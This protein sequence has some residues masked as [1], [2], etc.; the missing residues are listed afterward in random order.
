MSN[1]AIVRR[2]CVL[3]LLVA[4]LLS[5]L[6]ALTATVAAAGQGAAQEPTSPST[7]LPSSGP[8]SPAGE[9]IPLERLVVKVEPSLR[10]AMLAGTKEDV[11]VLVFS[12]DVPAL[13]RVME[14]YPHEGLLGPNAERSNIP[15]AIY[16]KMP[17]RALEDV[18]RLD[19]TLFVMREQVLRPDFMAVTAEVVGAE[20][21]PAV[22]KLTYSPEEIRS[23][24][25]GVPLM[26]ERAGAAKDLPGAP[27]PSS[28]GGGPTPT[29]TFSSALHHAF[30]ANANGYTGNGVQVAEVDLGVDFGH[31][32]LQGTW[33]LFNVSRVPPAVLAAKP[34]LANYDGWPLA[35]NADGV[36]AYLAGKGAVSTSHGFVSTDTVLTP[37]PIGADQYLRWNR[38]SPFVT[39]GDIL[40]ISTVGTWGGSG[41][42]GVYFNP[43]EPVVAQPVIVPAGTVQLNIVVSFTCADIDAALVYDANNN[44]VPEL[45]ELIS[46]APTSTGANPEVFAAILNPA[47]ANRWFVMLL[48][49]DGAPGC[50]TDLLISFIS[51]VTQTTDYRVTGIPSVSNQYHVGKHWDSRLVSRYFI[52]PGVLVVDSFSANQYDRVYVDL[53]NNFD[54]TDDTA[55]MR[56]NPVGT[57]DIP[58]DLNGDGAPEAPDGF[59]DLSSGAVV[60]ITNAGQRTGVAATVG[61][62]VVTGTVAVGG[63]VWAQLPDPG[64]ITNRNPTIYLNGNPWGVASVFDEPLAVT[65]GSD[66]LQLRTRSLIVAGSVVLRGTNVEVVDEHSFTIANPASDT[67]FT[68]DNSGLLNFNLYRERMSPTWYGPKVVP[69]VSGLD[70]TVALATGTVTLLPRVRTNPNPFIQNL[71]GDVMRAYYNYTGTVSPLDYSV[72]TST[73]AITLAYP[74]KATSTMRADY[75]Y[76]AWTLDRVTGNLSLT[77]A[78]TAGDRITADYQYGVTPLPY[79][80]VITARTGADNHYWGSGDLVMFTGALYGSHGTNVATM[81]AGQGRMNRIRPDPPLQSVVLTVPSRF[82]GMAPNAKIV[83]IPTILLT[84]SI[85][86][87]WYFGV[88]GYDGVPGTGDDSQIITNSWGSDLTLSS[89]FTAIERFADWL[90]SQYAGGRAIIVKSAGNNGYGYGTFSDEGIAGIVT[91]GASS[92]WFYRSTPEFV[93]DRGPNPAYGDAAGFSA[94]GPTGAGQ[95]GVDILFNGQFVYAA[96]PLNSFFDATDA[97]TL[98]SGTSFSAPLAAGALALIY[99]AF[100]QAHAGSFPMAGLAK[101]LLMSGADP[102][103]DAF[104]SGAGLGNALRSTNL[105]AV[106]G[107]IRASPHSWYPGDYRGTDYPLSVHLLAAGESDTGAITLTNEGPASATVTIGAT[108][109]Q[110]LN[111]VTYSFT[112]SVARPFMPTGQNWTVLRRGQLMDWFGRPLMTYDPTLWDNADLIRVT[113]SYSYST[114][115]S[116]SRTIFMEPF[117]WTDVSRNLRYWGVSTNVTAVDWCSTGSFFVTGGT[118]ATITM[119]DAA[120]GLPIRQFGTASPAGIGDVPPVND[121]DVSPDCNYIAVATGPLAG[122]GL[123]RVAVF[124]ANTGAFMWRRTGDFIGLALAISSVEFSPDSTRVAYS[125]SGNGVYRVL[126]GMAADDASLLPDVIVRNVASAALVSTAAGHR[127]YTSA[128]SWSPSGTRVISGAGDTAWLWDNSVIVFDVTTNPATFVAGFSGHRDRRTGIPADGVKAVGMHPDGVRVFSAGLDNVVNEWDVTAVPTPAFDSHV[129]VGGERD[130]PLSNPNVVPLSFSVTLNDVP[131]NELNAFSGAGDFRIFG[132]IGLLQ[133]FGGDSGPLAPGDF[134]NTTY[135]FTPPVS[136]RAQTRPNSLAVAPNGATM[137]VG[138]RTAANAVLYDVSAGLVPGATVVPTW[139]P[140]GM[141]SVG[142]PASSAWAFTGTYGGELDQWNPTSGALVLGAPDPWTGLPVSPYGLTGFLLERNRMGVYTPPGNV[143]EMRILDP[144]ARTH[145]GL[146]IWW[147][148]LA[149]PAVN[150]PVIVEIEFFQRRAWNW[151]SGIPASATVVPGTP[152][153]V[154]PIVT[155]PAGT[156]VGLYEGQIEVTSGTNVTTVP[157]VVN[158]ALKGGSIFSFGGSGPRRLYDNTQFGSYGQDADA[159]LY[160]FDLPD[161]FAMLPGQR[162]TV[163]MSMPGRDSYLVPRHTQAMGDAAFQGLVFSQLNPAR[164]GPF[165]IAETDEGAPGFFKKNLDWMGQGNGVFK[166]LSAGPGVNIL[167]LQGAILNGS[168]GRETFSGQTGLMSLSPFPLS[169]SSNQLKS[170]VTVA[171]TTTTPWQLGPD[172]FVSSYGKS[173][174]VVTTVSDVTVTADLPVAP[175]PFVSG[176]FIDYLFAAP[177]RVRTD[178]PAGT[179]SA[180][181]TMRFHSGASDVD[182]GLFYDDNCDGAYT[183]ADDAAGTVAATG[184]NPEAISLTFPAEGCYWL[185]AAGFEVDPG[186]LYDLT[187]AV[188]VIGVSAFVPTNLPT[189]TIPAN[190]Y[191]PFKI[192][193]DLPAETADDV[194]SSVFFISPG[195]APLSLAILV[196]FSL[197]I[198]RAAPTIS[199]LSPVPGSMIRDS[200][201]TI[202]ANVFDTTTQELDIYTP[203]LSVDGVDVTQLARVIPQFAGATSCCYNLLTMV[204]E[205]LAPLSDGSHTATIKTKDLAGNL[206][207]MSWSW[208]VDTGAP[209]IVLSS[210]DDR[211]I[212]DQATVEVRGRTESGATLTVKGSVVTV[213]VDGTFATTVSLTEGVNVIDILATDLLGNLASTSRTVVYDATGPTLLG[214]RSTEGSRTRAISTVI[215]GSSSEPL[216][217]VMVN[218]APAQVFADGSFA[219]PA[220]LAEG[221]NVFNVQVADFAGHTAGTSLTV[222]RDTAPPVITPTAPAE[223]YVTALDK[224]KVWINGTVSGGTTL[225]SVNGFPVATVDGPFSRQ[226]FLGLGTNVFVIEAKDDVGNVAT[227]TV[228]VTFA[229]I[230]VQQSY[231]TVIAI[232]AAVVLLVLGLLVGRMVWGRGGAPPTPETGPTPEPSAMEGPEPEPEEMPAEE[233][234][235]TEEEEL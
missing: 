222:T 22:T 84:S 63:E 134:V 112:P 61:N 158:V 177:N 196:P 162:W 43:A 156:P 125:S 191:T 31:P 188:T 153:V 175:Y 15:I 21:A 220:S 189:A 88:E 20:T 26:T 186:S 161:S 66:S 126:F 8:Q 211:M 71:G 69:L 107:G 86:Q 183:V 73:G 59:A 6:T 2:I 181:W 44:N 16:L 129:A 137:I 192:A 54:F 95:T 80:D 218:G 108:E 146:A 154:N 229:P 28:D 180:S 215:K 64:L 100:A 142:Y 144:S 23:L 48:A 127:D 41:Y 135:T 49:F 169:A 35:L 216:A 224:N 11:E 143:F 39:P 93:F 99:D 109:Y 72:S 123:G 57:A 139:D 149:G 157:V 103:N 114:F 77:V 138:S 102:S 160:F 155:I 163:D 1:V 217:S 13:A 210:P 200:R 121:I 136:F 165:V 30:E 36:N 47:T 195:N 145:A 197:R 205:P 17:A 176:A 203:T 97:W 51:I 148:H 81:I 33:A 25:A 206:A 170:D 91:V 193:W 168:A 167:Y 228:T 198:D 231:S 118:D 76:T 164:Y 9:P 233:E 207:S 14:K 40:G 98:T 111:S 208:Y 201:P 194:Q 221:A 116:A 56:G 104:K 74:L 62:V 83:A 101:E 105:A 106:R 79:S 179:M 85:V 60:H 87:G 230:V 178:V 4:L 92:S 96:S 7:S 32:E 182:Y 227:E 38:D 90:T 113:G 185:H 5:G 110:Y 94:M 24:K 82:R 209:S 147:R 34:Y 152:L 12:A 223:T 133:W 212:T 187:F 132:D 37:I 225:V 120:T 19:S 130:I 235:T 219:F 75:Q 174:G 226:F 27:T 67:T 150:T 65:A 204:Y 50:T 128:V 10:D 172:P 184:A 122:L 141:V 58:V 234:M 78:L 131:V 171:L 173:I 42:P 124:N 3:L 214:V 55:I 18:A 232:G 68:V 52:R 29:A 140:N 119:W 202:V 117:D 151:I 89:G 159:R 199:D 166:G 45:A 70:Y 53:N 190:S 213:G 46:Y 115:G